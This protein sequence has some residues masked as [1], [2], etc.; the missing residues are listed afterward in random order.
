MTRAAFE[1]AD[2]HVLGPNRPKRPRQIAL[3]GNR[4]D[5]SGR[6]AFT[7]CQVETKL[8]FWK[9][10]FEAL[11]AQRDA[12]MANYEIIR[13]Q[14]WRGDG[15]ASTTRP[16]RVM[17]GVSPNRVFR[18][19]AR[20]LRAGRVRSPDA[21][22]LRPVLFGNHVLWRDFRDPFRTPT[23]RKSVPLSEFAGSVICRQ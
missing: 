22:R 11:S 8:L 16:P 12:R 13:L 20:K 5:G 2:H 21:S 7:L 19:D 14:R 6:P 23:G 9:R 10:D 17:F 15:L 3:L 1:A 18:R 4:A